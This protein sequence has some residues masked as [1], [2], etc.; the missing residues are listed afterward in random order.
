[1]IVILPNAFISAL[2]FPR[3]TN[4]LLGAYLI[5]RIMHVNS[6]TDHR[7][8]NKAYAPE[9]FMRSISTMLI[10]LGLQSSFRL[11]G[12]PATISGRV[13]KTWVAQ[14]LGDTRIAKGVAQLRGR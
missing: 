2:N 12:I 14:K 8:H 3:A 9:E 4:F 5:L 11:T 10:L 13:G 6:Y 7:G 1:M